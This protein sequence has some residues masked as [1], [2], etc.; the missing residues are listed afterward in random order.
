[1]FGNIRRWWHT[2]GFGVHSPSAYRLIREVLC[3]SA[4]YGFYAYRQLRKMAHTAEE[5][6]TLCL[7]YRLLI[8]FQPRNVL[9][10]CPDSTMQ[11]VVGLAHGNSES[12][13]QEADFIIVNGGEVPDG[14]NP[15]AVFFCRNCV[16]LVNEY[17]RQMAKGH[18]FRSRRHA[19]VVLNENLPLQTFELNF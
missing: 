14:V 19:L 8:E 7:I 5:Y 15:A 1:M 18:I 4:R 6:R 3:P 16:G 13:P 17:A 12:S 2:R 9:I 10:T 11:S